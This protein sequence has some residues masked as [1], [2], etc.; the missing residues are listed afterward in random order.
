MTTKERRISQDDREE[1]REL[2]ALLKAPA[3][4]RYKYSINHITDSGN[5][6]LSGSYEEGFN[7]YQL[8]D[9]EIILPVWPELILE[10]NL[11]EESI[12]ELSLMSV[13]LEYFV[14]NLIDDFE[15]CSCMISV[16]SVKD[17]ENEETTSEIVSLERFI[18]DLNSYLEDFGERIN[19]SDRVIEEI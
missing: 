6:V 19:L 8:E 4:K 15:E 16:F 2:D 5:L 12:A 18:D 17:T 13:S 11:S 3:Q 1:N 9:G 10:M 7:M 14:E